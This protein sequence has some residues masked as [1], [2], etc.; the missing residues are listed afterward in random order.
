MYVGDC[1]NSSLKYLPIS[2][3]PII[4]WLSVSGNSIVFFD[5]RIFDQKHLTKINASSN[6]NK[7]RELSDSF[8]VNAKRLSSLDISN[9]KINSL[10]KNL[11]QLTTLKEMWMAGNELK[12]QCNNIFV[13]DWIVNNSNIV[14]DYDLVRCQMPD[15]TRI[16]VIQM[17]EGNLGCIYKF[18]MW[19]ISSKYLSILC[20]ILESKE[21]PMQLNFVSKC[22][23][24]LILCFVI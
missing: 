14:K 6:K 24:H 22:L 16:P 19:T 1:T 20:N 5:D 21:P 15:E 8:V 23:I 17:D 2:L 10:P 7:I 11:T 12:C 9:N 3:P 4:N 18:P 13:R